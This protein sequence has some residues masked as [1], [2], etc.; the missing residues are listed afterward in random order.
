MCS[1]KCHYGLQGCACVF[2]KDQNENLF[3]NRKLSLEN[4]KKEKAR[5][6]KRAKRT[7]LSSFTLLFTEVPV[8]GSMSGW[9]RACTVCM[10]WH[11]FHS[12]SMTLWGHFPMWLLP[13]LPFSL[14]L[15]S[16]PC[17]YIDWIELI[18]FPSVTAPSP[19]SGT[20]DAH[21]SWGR[22]IPPLPLQ[23]PSGSQAFFPS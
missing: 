23:Q 18:L 3:S 10:D 12:S 21:S 16:V 4:S 11:P 8:D 20:S 7:G 15:W 6:A 22:A 2:W 5:V 19:G 13:T 1:A 9:T 17:Y 14:T